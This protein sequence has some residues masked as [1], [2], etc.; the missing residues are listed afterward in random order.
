M[1]QISFYTS[2]DEKR[3]SYK[4]IVVLDLKLQNT[5]KLILIFYIYIENN[6]SN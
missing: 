4:C 2:C 5:L 6:S 3:S 1:C